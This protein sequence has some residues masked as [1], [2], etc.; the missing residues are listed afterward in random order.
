[1]KANKISTLVFGILVL[2]VLKAQAKQETWV[3]VRSPNFVVLTN[4][5]EKQAR[6]SAI[7]FEQIRALFRQNF[8]FATNAPSPVITIFAVKDESSLRELLP[9]YWAKGHAH[10][11]GIFF[12]RLNQFYVA[13][14]LDAPGDNPY[15]GIYHEYYHSI[16]LPFFP[17][18]PV[19]LAEGLADFFGNSHIDGDKAY[20]GE[21]DAALIQLL[22]QNRLIPLD[23]LFSVDHSSP[24]YNEESKISVFYAESWALTHYFMIGDNGAHR[25]LLFNYLSYLGQGATQQDAAAKA[26]GDFRA[27]QAALE[28]YVQNDQY[29][30]LHAPAPSKVADADLSAHTLSEAEVD[31]ERG[32]FEA[33]RGR[34]ADAKPLLEDAVR[35]DPKLALAHQ[36]LA[37]LQLFEG[38]KDQALDSLSQAIALDP[39]NAQT[40]YLRAYVTITEGPWA[41]NPQVEGDLRQAIAEDPT[42]AAPY[43]ML[44]VYLSVDPDT[45]SQALPLAK[46]AVQLE[47]GTAQY[48]VE[49]AQVLLRMRRYDDAQSMLL[50]ARIEAVSVGERTQ[51]DQMLNVLQQLRSNQKSSGPAPSENES[52]WPTLQHRT[53]VAPAAGSASASS[54]PAP[55]EITGVVTKMSCAPGIE[56]QI[57]ASS[58]GSY[59]LQ[60]APGGQF[61]FEMDEKPPAGFNPCSSIR[62]LQVT[63][64][65][66]PD[67]ASGDTGT[68]ELLEILGPD[69][70]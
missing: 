69:P 48:Q 59:R 56:I 6:K 24:Y 58:G 32:G 70:R 27:L 14:Q 12:S 21:P 62:G 52:A 9:E 31:A 46:K 8:Q 66:D 60:V 47:P 38:Q 40:R 42:F 10:P 65:Y 55:R 67:D 61:H 2:A 63:A 44:A 23:V 29:Y 37:I 26:F 15:M 53:E 28:R 16:S 35:L 57:E 20:M 3:E 25:Q 17:G 68:L 7:Q 34:L 50:R 49:I 19:W 41:R 51:V 18:M 30:D 5:G 43:A 11:A 45:L 54:P 36:N 33:A 4:A 13:I 39:N 22:R 64:H 1:M